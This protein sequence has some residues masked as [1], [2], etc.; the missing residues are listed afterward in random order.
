[1]DALAVAC[2]SLTEQ[3]DLAAAAEMRWALAADIGR[4][5]AGGVASPEGRGSTSAVK[6]ALRPAKFGLD[7]SKCRL[8][9][10]GKGARGTLKDA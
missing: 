9:L 5:V 2:A 8:R 1:M 6:M 4:G 7:V 10:G 3:E